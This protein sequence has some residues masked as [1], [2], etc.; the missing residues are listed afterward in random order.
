MRKQNYFPFYSAD[1]RQDVK[2]F[3][4]CN[5]TANGGKIVKSKVFIMQIKLAQRQ[6]RARLGK[7][8]KFHSGKN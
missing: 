6:S 8:Q 2:L 5:S 4:E 1:G 7:A 3:S